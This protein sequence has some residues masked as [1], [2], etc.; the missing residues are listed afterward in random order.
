MDGVST[1]D[2]EM[3]FDPIKNKY[4]YFRE[5]EIDAH[6]VF[7]TKDGKYI[8]EVIPSKRKRLLLN[9]LK[10]LTNHF[11]NTNNESLLARIYGLYTIKTNVFGSFDVIVLQNT[12]RK[13]AKYGI[14]LVFNITG[15]K[16][17]EVEF[18]SG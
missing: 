1:E 4:Q 16:E 8:V 10:Q 9:L 2:I 12:V 11:I 13:Y 14:P 17:R 18:S 15:T 5:E 7:N 6:Y 3:S